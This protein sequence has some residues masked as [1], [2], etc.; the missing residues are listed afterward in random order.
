MPASND[1][2]TCQMCGKEGMLYMLEGKPYCPTC[3]SKKR[4]PLDYRGPERRR[5]QRPTP[6]LR[7]TTDFRGDKKS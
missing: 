1:R 4:P 2:L 3:L 7:R 6:F 5:G